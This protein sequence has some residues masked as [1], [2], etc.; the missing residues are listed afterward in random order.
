MP[1]AHTTRID[2]R[3]VLKSLAGLSA[4]AVLG[5]CTDSR[6][7]PAP[8]ATADKART[9]AA[10]PWFTISLAEWSLHRAIRS[11]S[12]EHL[13]FPAVAV[14]E[15]G[16]DAV[17]YVNTLFKSKGDASYNRELRRRCDDLGVT[18]LLIMCDGEGQLGDPDSA[19]RTEAVDNHRKWLDAAAQLG[20]HSIRVNAASAGSFEEQQKLAADG[21]R[22]LCELGEAHGLNVIVENHGGWSSN[23]A[24]L[25]GVMRLVAHPRVGTLPDFGNFDP[26]TYDRYQGVTELMPFARGVSAKSYDFDATTGDETTIDYR[27]MLSIVL[28]AGYRGR[29]GIEYEGSRLSERDGI[30]ATRRLLERVRSEINA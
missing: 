28:A 10:T 20:C 24:W 13:D 30:L 9:D 2:R 7:L 12:L 25:A 1:T 4:A 23:G 5:S 26:K 29:I 22:R 18:S 19:R 6:V 14:N 3:S 27:R 21:L 11:G 15:H 8:S 16:I 17:E